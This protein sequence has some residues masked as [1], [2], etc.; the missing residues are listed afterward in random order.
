MSERILIVDDDD[1]LR[2]SLCLVLAS[3][4]YDVLSAHDGASALERIEAMVNREVQRNTRVETEL[5][6]F[7]QAIEKGA[8]ALFGEKYGDEVRLLSMGEGFSVELCGGCHVS[9][10]GDIGI[11]KIVSESGIAAGVR[12]IEAV[13]GPGA[14]MWID[15]GEQALASTSNLVKAPRRE[16]AAK[17]MQLLDHNRELQR[18]LER[19]KGK[20]AASAGDD[21]AD[22]AVDVNGLKVLAAKLDGA[23]PKSLRDTVD[24]LKNKLGSAAV[25]LAT[26]NDGKVALVAGVT[27]DWTD[28]LAAGPL[29]N[30]VAQQVG[31]RGGG[32]PDLAQ[33]GGSDPTHIDKAI[34]SVTGWVRTQ[35]GA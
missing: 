27:K 14:L 28:R 20:L 6:N 24:Q 33:A 30:H 21:L 16:V 3:E 25:V 5:T 18:E 11:L 12:R 15:E 7:D 17:V 35:L 10:T 23:D 13:T 8:M 9:R 1:S 29:A 26:V 22:R 31:G 19:L 32:R 4:G 34:D 2:E